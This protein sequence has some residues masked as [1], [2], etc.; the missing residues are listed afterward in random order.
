MA[1]L[2]VPVIYGSV[3]RERQ[4]IRAARYIVR[5]LQARGVNAVLVDPLEYKLP[6]LDLMYKEYPAGEA[7]EVLEKLATLFRA[8]DGFIVVSGEYNHSVP[9]AL[10]N[11]LDHFLEEY[12]WRPAG[13]V[14]YSGGRFSGVRAAVQLRSMLAEMGMVT[15]PTELPFA[16]VQHAFD[17]NGVPADAKTDTFATA[18]FAE[19]EWYVK[20]LA[21]ARASGVPD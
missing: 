17:E 15:I 16:Q 5:T 21:V 2:L 11:L 14:C 13:I 4:G 6:L 3:R 20:A 10:S 18:F 19:F 8:A 9:P 7:P 1:Q 12:F